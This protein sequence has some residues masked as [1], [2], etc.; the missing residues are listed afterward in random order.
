[1]L[2]TVR[3]VYRVHAVVEERNLHALLVHLGQTKA[4]EVTV[5]AALPPDEASAAV[6]ALLAPAGSPQL[7]TPGH[8]AS[9][10]EV[11]TYYAATHPTEQFTSDDI[12]AALPIGNTHA[13]V[14]Q[15]LSVMKNDGIL[16]RVRQGTYQLRKPLA[17]APAPAAATN[18]SGEIKPRRP[19][20]RKTGAGAFIVS[21]MQSAPD[22]TLTIRQMKEQ[23]SSN[24]YSEATANSMIQRLAR[25]L[26]LI[27]K[28][29]PGT[30]QL[31]AKGAA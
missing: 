21:V 9:A 28:T 31:T 18:G 29:A 11:A 25:Q 19:G 27:K 8:G 7:Q 22:Q 14:T 30:Y 4:L 20:E 6:D 5:Q 12:R 16:K 10:R 13:S 23:L 17:F 15:I 26:K 1:M 3:K 2:K 24:G